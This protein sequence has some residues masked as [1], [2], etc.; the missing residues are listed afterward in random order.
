MY[1]HQSLAL[2]YMTDREHAAIRTEFGTVTM[3][4]FSY[5]ICHSIGGL[6]IC[7]SH[8]SIYVAI[9]KI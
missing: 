4:I 2:L 3:N 5:F 1:T 7:L 6:V 9:N 8:D